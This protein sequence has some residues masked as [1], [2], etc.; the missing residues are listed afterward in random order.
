MYSI[1]T[2]FILVL[3]FL[4]AVILAVQVYLTHITQK[5]ILVELENLSKSIN[6]TTDKILLESAF[7]SSKT[8]S[9]NTF[10][11]KSGVRNDILNRIE[12][13]K[14][15]YPFFKADSDKITL[16]KDFIQH[17]MTVKGRDSYSYTWSNEDSISTF[18]FSK[19]E[20]KKYKEE[21][22]V[23]V[24]PGNISKKIP[25][26]ELETI[27]IDVGESNI[28]MERNV[29]ENQN[30]FV[31]KP[32]R[33]FSFSF[34]N[35]VREDRPQVVRYNYNTAAL[36]TA[37]SKMRDRNILSTI[38]LFSLSLLF[39]TIIS[40]SF[41]KPL[42]KL[43]KSFDK[44]V[45]GNFDVN[46]NINSRDE[47]AE[48]SKSF[49]TMVSELK[50]NKEREELINRQERLASVGQLAAGVAHEIKN[51]LNAI[52]LTISHLNDKFVNQSNPQLLG[53]IHTIQSEIKRLDKTVNDF[54]NYV[55]SEQLT[56]KSTSVNDLL[57]EILHL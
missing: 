26:P 55:R 36:N 53:Y 24:N 33:V 16:K 23:K 1:K 44:V 28:S 14:V 10:R 9:F 38:L 31:P 42:K 25:L 17:W 34:P 45:K 49:N 7:F 29:P 4:M 43:N 37:I 12:T 27:V 21:A 2:K 18:L 15:H 19:P 30:I 47:I 50:K 41:L 8:D 22:I 40:T 6:S 56:L 13:T 52:N 48:L 3:S 46:M 35:L 32:N 39:I 51:P 11:F 57:D 5:D 20:N 54:L